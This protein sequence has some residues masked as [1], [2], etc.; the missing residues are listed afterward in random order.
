MINSGFIESTN[1]NV[2]ASGG[3]SSLRRYKKA[4]EN[5]Y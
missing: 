2:I 1:I 4:K 5:Q 3:V